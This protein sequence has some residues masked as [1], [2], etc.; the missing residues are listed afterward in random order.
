MPT[1]ESSEEDRKLGGKVI[2]E[3]KEVD[4][5][6]LEDKHRTALRSV[7]FMPSLHLIDRLSTAWRRMR[8]GPLEAALIYCLSQGSANC[9]SPAKFS[10]LSEH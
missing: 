8:T 5:W 4:R 6:H 1:E 9:G 10:L 3:G 2:R 7:F